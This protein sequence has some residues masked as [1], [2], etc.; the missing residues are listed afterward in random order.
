MNQELGNRQV[1]TVDEVG[2]RLGVHRDTVL[3][4]IHAGAIRARQVG[5][6]WKIPLSA[7]GEYL[8]GRDN[9]LQALNIDD[10]AEALGAHRD[11]ITKIVNAGAIRA[12]RLGRTWKIPT[13]AM[14]EFLAGRDNPEREDG[15]TD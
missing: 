14:E 9:P 1:L 2:E 10:V 3:D 13:D 4:M 15:K 12:V 7:M 8:S 5:R 6:V 11:T